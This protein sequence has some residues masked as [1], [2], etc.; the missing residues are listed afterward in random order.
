MADIYRTVYSDKHYLIGV[1]LSNLSGVYLE[2]K[3]YQRAEQLLRD[4]LARFASTLPPEHPLAGVGHVRLGHVLVQQ[5]RF[6]E[7]ERESRAGYEIVIKKASSSVTWVRTAREDLAIEYDS[8]GQPAL[9]ERFR[10]EL[11]K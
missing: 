5:K 2:R 8:L 7:A 9:A 6:A 1:A 11:S 4:A 3:D 10:A